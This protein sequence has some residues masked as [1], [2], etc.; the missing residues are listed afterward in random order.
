M[1]A[2]GSALLGLQDEEKTAGSGG[3]VS[4]AGRRWCFAALVDWV[5]WD[6]WG[7]KPGDFT[8]KKMQT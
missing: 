6:F 5:C 1:A 4:E 2:W 7:Q 8:S 3:S